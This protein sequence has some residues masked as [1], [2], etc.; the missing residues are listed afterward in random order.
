MKFCNVTERTYS[1]SIIR[2]ILILSL[3]ALLTACASTPQINFTYD[4]KAVVETLTSEVS[5]SMQTSERG[6][7][8]SGFMAYQRPDKLHLLLLSPFG[9]TL[10]EVFVLDQQLYLIYPSQGVAYVGNIAEL[11]DKAGMHGWR[12]MRWVMDSEPPGPA[13][14]DGERER[15]GKSGIREIITLKS[16]LITAK[17]TTD[18]NQVYYGNYALINGIPLAAEIDIRNHLND[19]IR[20]KLIEP[21]VNMPLDTAAITPKLDGLKV[22]PLSKI[23]H[24]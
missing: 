19:Q 10:F 18:G 8:G 2:I 14:P 12:M 11:P 20:M 7:S 16:G 3:T 24:M 23:E 13:T 15:M 6:M 17:Q 22:L 5:I 1:M 21:E 9:T 4:P